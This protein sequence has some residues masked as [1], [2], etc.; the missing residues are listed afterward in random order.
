MFDLMPFDRIGRGDLQRFFD[1]FEKNFLGWPNN[2]AGFRTDIV[3]KGSQYVLEAELP[4]FTKEDINIDID[5]DRLTISA[6]H[7][8]ER[9]DKKENFVR[10]ERSYGSFSRS[11][12]I[13]NIQPDAITAEYKNGVLFLNL[14]KSERAAERNRRIDIQ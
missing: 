5:G 3:D 8:E 4:G 7:N 9:E 2:F 11:F 12:D 14:P 6:Q 13:S 10:R 1:D